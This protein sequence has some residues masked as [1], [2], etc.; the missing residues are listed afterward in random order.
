MEVYVWVGR[1]LTD[2]ELM[3]LKFPEKEGTLGY[4]TEIG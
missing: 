4:K 1:E 3:N 2:E